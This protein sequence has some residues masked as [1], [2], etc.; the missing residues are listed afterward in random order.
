[1]LESACSSLPAISEH[2]LNNTRF[3]TSLHS[4]PSLN[5]MASSRP[6][7]KGEASCA[8]TSVV[9]GQKTKTNK[10]VAPLTPTPYY[11]LVARIEFI[12]LTKRRRLTT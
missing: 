11:I 3:L 6:V 10:S 8:L 5:K 12:S 2:P 9:Y 7:Q 1:M 4:L